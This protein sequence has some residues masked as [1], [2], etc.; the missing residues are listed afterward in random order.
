MSFFGNDAINRVNLQSG[1]Q[2]LAQ[3]AGA[4]FLLHAGVSVPLALLAQA[5]IVAVRFVA[6][7][8][9]LPLAIRWGLKPL[10]IAGAVGMAAQ[11]PLLAEVRG[12]GP[13]LV[14]V[15]LAAAL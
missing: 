9:I 4:L 2:G 5:A 11:Y 1:V 7:P 3:G 13:A 10:M 14:A 12:V 6:R 15:V 8:L